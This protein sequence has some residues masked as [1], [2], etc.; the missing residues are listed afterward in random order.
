MPHALII[1]DDLNNLVVLQEMLTHQ[2]ISYTAVQDSTQ[3]ESVLPKIDPVDVIFLDLEMPDIDGYQMFE[4]LRSYP[5]LQK[6][7]I[8]A[9]TVHTGESHN[10]K[11]LGFHSFISKP[12]DV[13]RFP[14]QIQQI[15]SGRA[16]WDIK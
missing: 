2:G 16:V 15:L 8:T 14:E 13:H 7:P 9:Y 6:V 12:L 10:A 5:D 1:D 4:I 3:V 11:E